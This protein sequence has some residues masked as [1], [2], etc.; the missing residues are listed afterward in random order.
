MSEF[1]VPPVDVAGKVLSV[2]DSVAYCMAGKSSD[3]RVGPITRL[4]KKQVVLEYPEEGSV[5]DSK[6]QKYVPAII[7]RKVMRDFSNVAKV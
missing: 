3:M 4:T 6:Q 1:Q 2:G 5:W 7:Q